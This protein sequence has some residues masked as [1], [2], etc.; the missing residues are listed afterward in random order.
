MVVYEQED[1][2]KDQLLINQVKAIIE[3]ETDLIANLANISALINMNM[4]DINWV[5]FYLYKDNEL[6]L[7]PFQ[8]KVACTR[9]Y[10]GQGV[11]MYALENKAVTNIA[12]VHQFEGHVVCDSDSE[13]EL[14]V[15]LYKDGEAFG[16]LDIDA[17]IKNRFTKDDEETFKEIGLIIEEN[18]KNF[19]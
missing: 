14:V 8:G 11:C 18:L 6:V 16:V 3:D 9:L 2:M 15:P 12:D 4:E 17:P 10:H 7:G 19:K 5:G 1:V 13:S